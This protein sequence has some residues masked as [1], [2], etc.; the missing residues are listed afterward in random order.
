IA[1]RGSGAAQATL[2]LLALLALAVFSTLLLAL[3]TLAALRL[4]LTLLAVSLPGLR[5]SVLRL[6]IFVSAALLSRRWTRCA[7]LPVSRLTSRGL[8]DLAIDLIGEVL[9]LALRAPQGS[10]LVA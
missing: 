5:L 8:R 3:L 9:Q 10:R 7:A 1:F 4:F 6:R 2:T